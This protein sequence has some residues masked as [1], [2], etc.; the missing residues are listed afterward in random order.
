MNI[1]SN[2]WVNLA[3]GI[4]AIAGAIVVALL[5]KEAIDKAKAKK[6]LQVAPTKA[7]A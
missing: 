3:I 4:S 7:V 5:A 6:H 1:V 2:K